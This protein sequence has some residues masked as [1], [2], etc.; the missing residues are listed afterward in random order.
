MT[1]LDRYT[2]SIS[3][4][5]QCS[6]KPTHFEW[7]LVEKPP[8]RRRSVSAVKLD[9]W[10]CS[11]PPGPPPASPHHPAR[12]KEDLRSRALAARPRALEQRVRYIIRSRGGDTSVRPLL[13]KPAE[14]PP[15]HSRTRRGCDF[16]FLP[17]N[18]MMESEAGRRTS[19]AFVAGTAGLPAAEEGQGRT[20]S[21]ADVN[22]AMPCFMQQRSSARCSSSA[23]GQSAVF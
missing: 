18:R 8:P 14:P 1:H 6:Y 2:L 22:T 11:Y 23:P 13:S 16:C 10:Q 21:T 3:A 12:R 5:E 4:C 15:A 20:R 19:A 9:T 17:A 7:I